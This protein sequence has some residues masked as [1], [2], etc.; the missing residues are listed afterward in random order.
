MKL[1]VVDDPSTEP[2]ESVYY[3]GFH[4]FHAFGSEQLLYGGSIGIWRK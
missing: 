3:A 1:I 2:E 4:P